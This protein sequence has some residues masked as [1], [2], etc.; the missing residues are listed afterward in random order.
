MSGPC[1]HTSTLGIRSKT[2]DRGKVTEWCA[3]MVVRGKKD[4]HPR[5]AVDYQKLNASSLRETHYIPTPFDLV[6]NVPQHSYKTTADAAS[7]FHQVEL[8]DDSIKLTTF[9]TK[10]GRY[11]YL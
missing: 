5:R 7:G 9:I 6:S 1:R 2:D 4:G 3:R 11:Q 8:D 10:W